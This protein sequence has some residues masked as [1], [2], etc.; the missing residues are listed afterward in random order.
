MPINTTNGPFG[1]N[2]NPKEKNLLWQYK[3][4][5]IQGRQMFPSLTETKCK[6]Q[7]NVAA[8]FIPTVPNWYV[9]SFNAQQFNLLDSLNF[10]V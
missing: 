8:V 1:K 3:N 4:Q 5:I 2:F 6:S 10:T 9:L 7:S